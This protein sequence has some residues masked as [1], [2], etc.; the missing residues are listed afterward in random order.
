MNQNYKFKS[1]EIAKNGQTKEPTKK[2]SSTL[3]VF[4]M[5]ETRTIDFVLANGTRQNFAYAHYMTTWIGKD[6][7]GE[8]NERCIKI[9]F[10]T[11]LVTIRGYCLDNLYN[12]LI[13]L[14]VKSI[15]VNDERY[16]DMVN[17]GQPFVTD[18]KVTWKK[19]DV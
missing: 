4:E 13:K 7:N 15:K 16:L 3:S 1:L 8:K 2:E 17:E 12:E 11:H 9:F 5:G 10:A 19:E 6:E 18:I 14:S